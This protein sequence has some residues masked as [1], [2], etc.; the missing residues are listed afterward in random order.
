VAERIEKGLLRSL[1]LAR[2]SRER[3]NNSDALSDKLRR[4]LKLPVE[5]VLPCSNSLD[6]SVELVLPCSNTLDVFVELVLP[7]S[8]TLDVFVELVLPCSNSLEVSVELVVPP[9]GAILPSGD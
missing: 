1:E 4:G 9:V 6:V 3:A 2:I 5:L 7:C 8:N